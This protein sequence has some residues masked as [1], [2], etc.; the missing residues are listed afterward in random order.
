MS[1]EKTRL[2]PKSFRISEATAEKFKEI[3]GTIGGNQEQTLARLIEVF[4]SQ[5]AKAALP[6]QAHNIEMFEQYLSTIKDAYLLLLKE[7]SEQ[8]ATIRTDYA[9]LLQAKDMT[10]TELRAQIADLTKFKAENEKLKEQ[11]SA[12]QATLADK[13]ALNQSLYGQIAGLQEQAQQTQAIQALIDHLQGE[14]LRK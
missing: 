9:A 12:L 4:E 1:D 5:G 2:T 7:N 6:D 11:I 10:I 13:D 8:A 14:N 3:A